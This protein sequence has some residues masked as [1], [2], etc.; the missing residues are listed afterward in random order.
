M[1][2]MKPLDRDHTVSEILRRRVSAIIR[3]NDEQTA[4]DAIAAAVAGGIR[5]VEF[6][7]TT[8]GAL[9]LVAEFAANPDLIVGAGTVLTVEQARQAVEAG[10]RFLVSP[11]GDPVVIAEAR[12]LGAASIPGTLTPTEMQAAH[13]AGA[14]VVKLFPAPS[15]PVADYVASI[16]GPLP[17]L[18][19]F[20]T[21][22]F[23]VDNFPDVLRAGA[24]GVGFVK[25]LFDPAD[26]AERKFTAIEARAR[27]IVERLAQG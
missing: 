17:H 4:R 14:D 1:L 27:R 21:A 12:R 25:A 26:L 16:L 6:T 20:P 19:I 24:V 18:R 5:M 23:T 3:T 10:A 2:R 8:P 15:M 7:L 22:G 9:K 13:T 11:I